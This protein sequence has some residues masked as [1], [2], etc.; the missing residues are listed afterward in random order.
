MC[1]DGSPILEFIP[2]VP[3]FVELSVALSVMFFSTLNTTLKNNK[4]H[5]VVL[6]KVVV[7]FFLIFHDF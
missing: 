4:Q 3:K 7:N 2:R 5:Q 6:E 1:M